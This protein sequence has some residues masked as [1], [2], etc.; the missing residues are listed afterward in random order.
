MVK[1][2]ACLVRCAV[3]LDCR[4]EVRNFLIHAAKVRIYFGFRKWDFGFFYQ[5]NLLTIL[6][7]ATFHLSVNFFQDEAF[8]ADPK[9]T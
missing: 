8:P 6:S 9:M 5:V 3:K 1:I 2:A 7:L 4:N